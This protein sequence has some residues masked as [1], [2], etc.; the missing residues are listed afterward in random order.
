MV[1]PRARARTCDR[2]HSVF[3]IE[4][5][6]EM[7]VVVRVKER[8]VVIITKRARVRVRARVIPRT[9]HCC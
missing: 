7:C 1:F 4:R 8:H 6:K 9:G 2:G 3:I 5:E